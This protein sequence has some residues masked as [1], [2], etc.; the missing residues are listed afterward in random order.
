M[1]PH[2][3]WVFALPSCLSLN[4]F[5]AIPQGRIPLPPAS[6]ASTPKSTPRAPRANLRRCHD[7]RRSARPGS[8]SGQQPCTSSRLSNDGPDG[9]SAAS[10][11]S[12]GS[13]VGLSI[14]QASDARPWHTRPST[15]GSMPNLLPSDCGR[16]QRCARPLRSS[17]EIL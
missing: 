16:C 14:P 5:S 10:A 3:I 8:K 9:L 6:E 4:R 13:C 17:T 11:R 2:S 15:S 1:V 7:G 12:A